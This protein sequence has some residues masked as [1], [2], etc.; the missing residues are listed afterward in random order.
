[1][2][3]GAEARRHMGTTHWRKNGA[4]WHFSQRQVIIRGQINT[5][6]LNLFKLHAAGVKSKTQYD[7]LTDLGSDY[8][9]FMMVIATK[10]NP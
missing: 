9:I 1:M 3:N 7:S 4:I 8:S 5:S 10:T 2:P 6:S